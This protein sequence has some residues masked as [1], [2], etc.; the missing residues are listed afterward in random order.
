[1][2][3]DQVREPRVSQPFRGGPRVPQPII[4]N[5]HAVELTRTPQPPARVPHPNRRGLNRRGEAPSPRAGDF[6]NAGQ[7]V[8]ARLDDG[9][10][11]DARGAHVPAEHLRTY[12]SITFGATQFTTKMLNYH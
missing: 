11:L 3:R 2:R 6:Q 9:D 1:M 5:R 12:Q 4:R 10:G 7:V 8:A